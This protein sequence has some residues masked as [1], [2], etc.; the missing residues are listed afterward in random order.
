MMSYLPEYLLALIRLLDLLLVYGS[1]FH[2]S[3]ATSYVT[4]FLIIIIDKVRIILATN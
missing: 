1:I 3:V 4:R 2:S